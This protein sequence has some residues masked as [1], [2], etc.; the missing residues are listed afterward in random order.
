[1]YRNVAAH[2]W[3]PPNFPHSEITAKVVRSVPVFFIIANP[4]VK[5]KGRSV[6]GSYVDCSL[7]RRHG[8]LAQIAAGRTEM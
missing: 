4:P 3:S 8:N 1:M 2:V 7:C 5:P 6:L